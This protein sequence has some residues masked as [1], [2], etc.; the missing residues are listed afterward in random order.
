MSLKKGKSTIKTP[1]A[2]PMLRL[3]LFGFNIGASFTAE[4]GE[5]GVVTAI[6]TPPVI[7]VEHR[8]NLMDAFRSFQK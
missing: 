8:N 2:E 5:S 1:Y 3:H 6:K 4:Q 7:Q